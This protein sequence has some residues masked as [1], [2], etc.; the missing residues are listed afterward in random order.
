MEA[1]CFSETKVNYYRSKRRHIPE[2]V[3]LHVRVQVVLPCYVVEG[4]QRFLRLE[5]EA[6]FPPKLL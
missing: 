1:L 6:D 5:L 2:D 4:H 3:S